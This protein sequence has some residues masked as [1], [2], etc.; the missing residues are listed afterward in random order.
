MLAP[1]G[2]EQLPFCEVTIVDRLGP[3]AIWIAQHQQFPRHVRFF[4]RD[5]DLLQ[6][7]AVLP[8]ESGEFVV[9]ELRAH[10]EP[11]AF[12]L[13]LEHRE[14]VVVD[15]GAVDDAFVDGLDVRQGRRA[16][17][18][19]TIKERRGRV[20]SVAKIF[21]IP[22]E[23]VAIGEL[24]ATLL[25]FDEQGEHIACVGRRLHAI[26]GCRGARIG[27][28]GGFLDGQRQAQQAQ[29]RA[30]LHELDG[31]VCGTSFH[32]A[33]RKLRRCWRLSRR[34]VE[35]L[36]KRIHKFDGV[37]EHRDDY[38]DFLNATDGRRR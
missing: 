9:K 27:I 24:I 21:R 31:D 34:C 6:V 26:R 38:G 30:P 12:H 13:A 10:L 7:I 2:A 28:R 35:Q 29:W 19:A 36:E 4:G 20:V 23:Q 1:Q 25:L 14:V 17:T 22:C 3:A 8:E 16:N 11:D 37:A 32:A 5:A 15:Q 18:A 33:N